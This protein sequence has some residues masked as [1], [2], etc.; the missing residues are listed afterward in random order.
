[1]RRSGAYSS[2]VEHLPYKEVVA[3]S[4]PAAPTERTAR[5]DFARGHGLSR[6]QGL[7]ASLRDALGETRDVR[8]G[9]EK[10]LYVANVKRARELA[11][12]KESTAARVPLRMAW[13]RRC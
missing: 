13:A 3:G 5:Y 2:A 6:D 7:P 11:L 12:D 10:I 4:I 9:T 8:D 1:V